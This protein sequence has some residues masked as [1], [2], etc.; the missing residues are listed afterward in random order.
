MTFHEAHATRYLQSIGK[1]LDDKAVNL[2]KDRH[3]LSLRLAEENTEY[4]FRARFCAEMRK[5]VVYVVD[6]V[7]NNL[8]VVDL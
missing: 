4:Y 5:S 2:Y 6:V 8:G 3:L 1:S 7:L